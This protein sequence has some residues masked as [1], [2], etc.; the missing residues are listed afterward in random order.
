[1][2]MMMVFVKFMKPEP[3]LELELEPA[4]ASAD[5]VSMA[6]VGGMVPVVAKLPGKERERGIMVPWQDRW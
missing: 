4:I 2:G 6:V 1:M 5:E 3:E